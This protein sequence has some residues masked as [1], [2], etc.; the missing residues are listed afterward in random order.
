MQKE[1]LIFGLCCLYL[2]Y[3]LWRLHRIDR[4]NQGDDAA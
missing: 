3:V 4:N 1:L 2:A